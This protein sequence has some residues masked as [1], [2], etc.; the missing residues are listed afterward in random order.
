M[1]IVAEIKPTST[2]SFKPNKHSVADFVL[3][4]T[5][6]ESWKYTRVGAIDSTWK[7]AERN[8]NMVVLEKGI[9]IENGFIAL[10]TAQIEGVSFTAG[11][12]ISA[13]Q[14]ALILSLLAKE[15]RSDVFDAI[16]ENA[17]NDLVLIEIQSGKIIEDVISVE[18]ENTLNDCMSAPYVFIVSK[19]NSIAK[20]TIDFKGKTD[21]SFHLVQLFAHIEHS[22]QLEIHQL[23]NTTKNECVLLRESISQ[24][25]KSVFKITTVTAN[26]TWVRNELNIRI[27]GQH[28]ET[29]LSGAYFPKQDQLIDNHTFVD[30]QVP[31]CYS[32]ELYKGVLFDNGKGVFNGK[33]Y[34]HVD[35]Q[36]TNAYQSNANIMMSDDAS[37]FTKPELEIYADDVKCSHGT[38]TG[39][40]DEEALFYLRARGLS[41]ESAKRLLVSAFTSDVMN[42]ISIPSWK[43]YVLETLIKNEII[44]E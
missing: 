11:K 26:G 33:V 5:R 25:E 8:E 13:E 12:N 7:Q 23:Q 2:F 4:T 36:K 41:E 35:A 9:R 15:N 40:F 27:E 18:I 34:V 37:M 6:V 19:E 44:T 10:P 24:E 16:S 14:Q 3:P 43:E 30:H 29:F 31:N 28:C 42:R 17:S 1:S 22:A 32:N 20:F 39:Q 38:T 21:R